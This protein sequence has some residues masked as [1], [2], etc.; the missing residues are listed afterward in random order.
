MRY[1]QILELTVM[2]VIEADQAFVDTIS[3]NYDWVVQSDTA[4][5]GDAYDPATKEFTTPEPIIT[6]EPPWPVIRT[7]GV[8][9]WF[10]RWTDEELG[11][12]IT[13]AESNQGVAGWNSWLNRQSAV[14]LD[15]LRIT[16]RLQ[17]AVT[18]GHITQIRMDELLGDVQETEI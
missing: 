8:S 13:L 7:I 5:M 17:Q 16:V 1:A 6:P 18:G 15:D 11:K 3:H 4:Q 12:F 14:D 9:Q 2:N 10:N